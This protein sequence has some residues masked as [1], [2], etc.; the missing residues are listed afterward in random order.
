MAQ[1]RKEASFQNSQILYG[2]VN[3]NILSYIRH[4]DGHPAYLVAVNLGREP[5]TDSYI[6]KVRQF[7]DRGIIV[8]SRVNSD[9]NLREGELLS[10]EG[11][12]TLHPGEGVIVRLGDSVTLVKTEL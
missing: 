2:V 12:V 7:S 3:N 11:A 4:T 8:L 1:L 9:D 6:D 10:L 5:S